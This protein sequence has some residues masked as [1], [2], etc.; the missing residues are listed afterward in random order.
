MIWVAIPLI[1]LI[2]INLWET[3]TCDDSGPLSDCGVSLLDWFDL[4]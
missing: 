2:A 3:W 4:F 1:V